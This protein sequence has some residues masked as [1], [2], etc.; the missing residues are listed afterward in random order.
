MK[1]KKIWKVIFTLMIVS[2]NLYL[3][4]G[5][6]FGNINT[7]NE[8]MLLLLWATILVANPLLLN[9]IWK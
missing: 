6:Y 2:F 9:L 4:F 8:N 5:L 3:Y 1:L 7:S